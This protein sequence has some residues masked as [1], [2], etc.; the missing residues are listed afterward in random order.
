MAKKITISVP[1]DL[2]EKMAEWKS[3]L[4]FSKVFQTAVANMIRKKEALRHRINEE[5]DLASIIDR[6]K[7]EKM[8]FENNVV[9]NG[10]KDGLEWSKTA[11]YRDI[12]YALS[13]HPD[14]KPD[15]DERLGDY[16]SQMLTAYS[17][18]LSVTGRQAQKR[19]NE[20][21]RQYL[22]GWKEGVELFWNEVK[23]KL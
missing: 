20:L 21:S 6:L 12:Q 4:N 3:A 17:R 16:F 2:H 15:K 11:H 5:I 22:D 10:K 8:E 9:E 1:D 14:D 19:L 7:R 18:K 13:W 23:D